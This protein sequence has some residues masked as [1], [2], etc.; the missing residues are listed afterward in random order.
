MRRPLL[1]YVVAAFVLIALVALLVL[2]PLLLLAA[3]V[4]FARVVLLGKPPL[5]DWRALPGALLRVLEGD[6]VVALALGALAL[7]ALM[8]LMERARRA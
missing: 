4:D 7:A 1:V 6:V 8:A 3:A 5:A 2:L